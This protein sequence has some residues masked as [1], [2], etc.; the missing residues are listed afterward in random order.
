MSRGKSRSISGTE[1]ISSLRKRPRKRVLAVGDGVDVRQADQVADDRADRRPSSP[2]RW[3][4]RRTTAYLLRHS[5]GELEDLAVDEE[6]AGEAVALHQRQLLVQ[7]LANLR[8]QT[9]VA[10]LGPPGAH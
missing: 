3:P 8:R 4:M 9:V 5:V 7:P 2:A 10:V 1:A 6:E